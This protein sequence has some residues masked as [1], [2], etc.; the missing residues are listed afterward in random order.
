ML[1]SPVLFAAVA[2]HADPAAPLVWAA[3]VAPRAFPVAVQRDGDGWRLLLQTDDALSSLHVVG[4]ELRPEAA[5]PGALGDGGVLALA[6]AP[7]GVALGARPSAWFSGPERGFVVWKESESRVMTKAELVRSSLHGDSSGRVPLRSRWVVG[8][9]T[10]AAIAPVALP[11]APADVALDWVYGAVDPE[12]VPWVG[13]LRSDHGSRS[14]SVEVFS[15]DA[16]VPTARGTLPLVGNTTLSGLLS[17]AA[18]PVVVTTDF[19]A[20]PVPVTLTWLEPA[21][22]PRATATTT[23]D[24]NVSSAVHALTCGGLTWVVAAP[25]AGVHHEVRVAGFDDQ[26]TKRA[27]HVVYAADEPVSPATATSR[28]SLTPAFACG[29]DRAAYTFVLPGN[30]Q[31]ARPGRAVL[32][33]WHAAP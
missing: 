12:G 19:T 24:G 6:G 22:T 20:Q 21:G 9:V 32:V 14:R 31:P 13:Q 1:R 10:P 27:E 8:A 7:P 26:G 28:V 5:R 33:T 15:I 18:G 17:T 3:D 25:M 16:G 29:G 4:A 30:D 2:A 23:V 11:W